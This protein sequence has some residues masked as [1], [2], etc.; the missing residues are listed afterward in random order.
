MA[1]Q[2]LPALFKG[3]THRHLGTGEPV[4]AV[5]WKKD[6]DH[7]KVE[8]YPIEKRSYKGLLIA[9]EKDSYALRFG[10]WVVE[11]ESGKLRVVNA[12]RFE[13]QYKPVGA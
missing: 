3:A 12:G 8:R 4:K 1:E 11:T 6:G 10:D 7:P 2:Q 13:S 9:G 5:Q